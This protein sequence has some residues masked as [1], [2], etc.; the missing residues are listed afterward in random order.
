MDGVH[1]VGGGDPED[2]GFQGLSPAGGLRDEV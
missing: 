1:A 2:S